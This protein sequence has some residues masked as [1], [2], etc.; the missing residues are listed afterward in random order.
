MD[1]FVLVTGCLDDTS[2]DGGLG[3][4]PL[5]GPINEVAFSQP[6]PAIGGL[7]T[8]MLVAPQIGCVTSTSDRPWH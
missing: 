5:F 4:C 2:H 7:A 6:S 1:Q 8:A 3:C